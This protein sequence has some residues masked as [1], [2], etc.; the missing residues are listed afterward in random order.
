MLVVIHEMTTN[1]ICKRNYKYV[2]KSLFNFVSFPICRVHPFSHL[3]IASR[4]PILPRHKW[5]SIKTGRSAGS[6]CTAG[7]VVGL[8]PVK[9]TGSERG[10]FLWEKPQT[11][12]L[13]SLTRSSVLDHAS[14][15]ANSSAS[16]SSPKLDRRF[17]AARPRRK[18]NLAWR[19]AKT[20]GTNT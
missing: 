1:I 18:T 19:A 4:S 17:R 6:S 11:T 8:L 15:R 3:F 7:Q 14:S 9:Q 13:D 5:K 12:S 20:N 16:T 2:F 10:Q